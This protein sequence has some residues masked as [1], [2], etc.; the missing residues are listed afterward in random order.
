MWES[1]SQWLPKHGTPMLPKPAHCWASHFCAH[2]YC[3]SSFVYWIILQLHVYQLSVVVRVSQ[4]AMHGCRREG[5]CKI[6]YHPSL[7]TR[8]L[9]GEYKWIDDCLKCISTWARVI[10]LCFAGHLTVCTIF[11]LEFTNRRKEERITSIHL[12]NTLFSLANSNWTL[13]VTVKQSA[14][15]GS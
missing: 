13:T 11:K 3:S 6:S 8:E 9:H 10:L 2:S 7:Q 5:D 1:S 12:N 15:R 4:D 14:K